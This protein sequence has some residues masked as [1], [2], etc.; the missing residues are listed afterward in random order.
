MIIPNEHLHLIFKP[1]S[2]VNSQ[3]LPISDNLSKFFDIEVVNPE[4]YLIY[5]EGKW[6][7]VSKSSVVIGEH[8]ERKDRTMY[9]AETVKVKDCEPTYV[10]HELGTFAPKEV[11]SDNRMIYSNL[12]PS[13]FSI[14]LVS[15]GKLIALK[16]ILSCW[17]TLDKDEMA[18]IS[19]I[20]TDSQVTL[21][22]SAQGESWCPKIKATSG[23][24]TIQTLYDWSESA[25]QILVALAMNYDVLG[26]TATDSEAA[27][28]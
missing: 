23:S 25:S 5:Y 20:V 7:E 2:Y 15:E 27:Q 18:R 1:I 4:T 9:Y 26:E 22:P 11:E 21:V 3:E 14:L 16:K 17:T 28:E 10:I 13:Q 6:Y 24:G 8:E 19:K 12:D